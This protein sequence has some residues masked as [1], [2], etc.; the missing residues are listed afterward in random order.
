MKPTPSS[1]AAPA[2][3]TTPRGMPSTCLPPLRGGAA[4]CPCPCPWSATGPPRGDRGGEDGVLAEDDAAPALDPPLGALQ[5]RDV[6]AHARGGERRAAP[7]ARRDRHLVV[8][9]DR[10]PAVVRAGGE[11]GRGGGVPLVVQGRVPV[12][13]P[14]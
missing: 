3:M 6:R 14:A 10:G 9:V 11:Q 8:G 1:S 2:A 7:P 4:A 5:H 12:G 13:G